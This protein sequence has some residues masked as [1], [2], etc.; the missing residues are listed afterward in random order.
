LLTPEFRAKSESSPEAGR[1][2]RGDRSA[3]A[4][5]FAAVARKV[6]EKMDVRQSRRRRRQKKKGTGAKKFC[7]AERRDEGPKNGRKNVGG[8]KGLEAS[9][10]TTDSSWEYNL[11]GDKKR[12]QR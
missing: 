6:A 9:S 7:A 3:A 12:S 5:I 2:K 8:Q 11:R 10:L 4:Q 1:K